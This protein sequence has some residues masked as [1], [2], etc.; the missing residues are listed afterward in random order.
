MKSI[1]SN[2]LKMLLITIVGIFYLYQQAH[3]EEIDYSAD[4]E[5]RAKSAGQSLIGKPAPNMK[6]TTIDGTTIDL[7]ELYGKKPI[8][9]K[10]W[11]TWCIPCREQM[12][13][14]EKIYNKYKDEIEVISVNT[15]IND[16]LESV[17][18]FISKMGLTMPTTIDDG[19]LARSFQLRVTPQ[20]VL[21][22]R[23]GLFSYFG[24]VDDEDFHK[25]LEH[26]I[27]QS[28][29]DKRVSDNSIAADYLEYKVGD[30]VS[31]LDFTTINDESIEIRFSDKKDGK[32]GLAFFG[33]WCEWYLEETAPKSSQACTK[34][35]ELLELKSKKE[36]IEWISISTN[37]WSSVSELEE[38]KESYGTS[39]PIV[40]DRD[41]KL[42]EMFGVNQIPTIILIDNDGKIQ[43]KVSVQDSEF[44][45]ALKSL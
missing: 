19:T 16:N 32:V 20:H 38:Y 40:F 34:V 41:G 15:G 35:R 33:P 29:N 7:N 12:P 24:H 22:D 17:V 26:I 39:L 37:V 4:G 45:D 1:S 23:Q 14:F 31:E 44:E 21:I 43:S 9:I 27:E 18:P 30:G 28:S 25:Q 10:F 36:G 11:A 2:Y 6:I 8:Y 5:R 42:F 13:G 3:A